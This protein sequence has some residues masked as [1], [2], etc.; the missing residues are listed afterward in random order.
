VK[1][2]ETFRKYKG[3]ISFLSKMLTILPIKIR[4]IMWEFVV[5]FPGKIGVG[6]RYIIMS[7]LI[8]KCGNNVYIGQ[9][10]TIKNIS[11]LSFGDN[12]SIHNNCY[13]DALGG[14]S[15]GDNVSIAHNSS[16]LSFDHTWDDKSIPIK[17]NPLKPSSVS[18]KDDVWIGCGCRIMSGVIINSRS[19]IAAGAV[20]NKEVGSNQIVG[21]I[22]GRTI[23]KI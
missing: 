6:L 4:S 20:I 17:Y 18:I 22:P 8:K 3:I 23:K 2:R 9:G 21:G 5:Y 15:I 10:V 1:G 19:I 11:N 13:I 16:I 7:S 12:V 14:I